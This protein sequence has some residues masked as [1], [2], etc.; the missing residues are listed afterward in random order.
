MNGDP[1][2]GRGGGGNGDGAGSPGGR[3]RRSGGGGGAIRRLD[4]VIASVLASLARLVSGASVFYRTASPD[5][6]QRV[7]FANHTSHLDFVVLWSALP[8]SVRAVTRPVAARDY[9]EKGAVRRYLAR[10][11]FRAILIQRSN[12]AVDGDATLSIAAARR[13]ID[14]LAVSMGDRDS[15]IVFPEGTRGSGDQIAPFKSGIYHLCR[16]KPGLELVPVYLDNMNRIL[17]KGELLPVPMLSRVVFGGPMT[18]EPGE[19]KPGFLERARAA[20]RELSEL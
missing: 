10:R 2:V 17:P 15:I 12:H 18:L 5:E 6:R 20:V 14:R 16:M 19:T 1:A 3:R 13:T 8:P 9:W 7:Y 11:V 4:G